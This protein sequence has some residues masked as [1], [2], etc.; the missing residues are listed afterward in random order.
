MA[1]VFRVNKVMAFAFPMKKNNLIVGLLL[2]LMCSCSTRE[3][4]FDVNSQTDFTI[5]AGLSIF[6]THNF[7]KDR[8]SIPVELTVQNL[9]LSGEDIAEVVPFSATIR[10]RFNDNADLDFINAVNIYLIE[11]PDFR[12]R[13]LFYLDFVPLGGKSEIE[14]LPTLIN[15]RDLLDN[16]RA[17]IEISLEFRQFPPSTIDMRAQMQ[18]SGFA[19]E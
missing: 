2:L 6:E 14:L 8:V 1:G 9:G 18:F 13:E 10:S 11:T 3:A 16:D 15:I 4:L 17:I 12:R 5:G 7:V 19:S